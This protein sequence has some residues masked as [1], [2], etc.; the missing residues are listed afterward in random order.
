MTELRPE[1]G[2]RLEGEPDVEAAPDRSA[3]A[4]ARP[5][6]ALGAF[7]LRGEVELRS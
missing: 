5:A 3:E 4:I 1:P 2:P 7:A 6:R